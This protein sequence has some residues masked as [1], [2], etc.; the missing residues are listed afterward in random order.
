M[1]LLRCVGFDGDTPDKKHF[2]GLLS[3]QIVKLQPTASVFGGWFGSVKNPVRW[4]GTER[5]IAPVDNW[6]ADLPKAG[7]GFGNGG[8]V[9]LSLIHI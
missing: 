9:A 5:G 3:A 4:I 7:D 8:G 2:L 1:A 6:S